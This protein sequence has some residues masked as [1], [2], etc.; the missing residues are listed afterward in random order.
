M[1]ILSNTS[2]FRLFKQLYRELHVS[3]VCRLNPKNVTEVRIPVPWGHIAGKWWGD[4]NK[5]PI[6]AFH[7][8]QDNA[9][10]FDPLLELLPESTSVLAIDSPGH[11]LSSHYPEAMLYHNANYVM[12]YPRIMKFFK[13]NQ[14]LNILAHSEGGIISFLFSAI[15]P[16][17]VNSLITLD[18]IKPFAF[19]DKEM[20]KL[21]KYID[22]CVTKSRRDPSENPKYTFEEVQERW[23]KGSRGSLTPDAVQILMKRGTVYD[24]ESGKYTLTR[25]PRLKIHSLQ[26]FDENQSLEMARNLKCHYLVLRATKAKFFDYSLKNSPNFINTVNEAAKSFKLV[27]VEGPHH[28]HLTHPERVA[29]IITEFIMRCIKL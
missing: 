2:S 29:P 21:G 5:Q 4:T 23:L 25:D 22:N 9:G 18:V 26:R 24:Q 10:T 7:G 11:G 8:W 14:K 15:Y 28:V 27:N 20:L 12:V 19:E 6:V 13:W 17:L 16:E 3:T 1:G